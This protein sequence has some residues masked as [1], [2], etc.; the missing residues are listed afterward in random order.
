MVKLI[1]EEVFQSS[2]DL[3][4]VFS[5]IIRKRFLLCRYDGKSLLSTMLH[6]CILQL[7]GSS[8]KS[9]LILFRGC[10]NTCLNHIL[11]FIHLSVTIPTL[12]QMF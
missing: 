9:L 4:F 1:K 12:L 3:K 6:S 8:G 5:L 10:R 2:I 11:G 7:E